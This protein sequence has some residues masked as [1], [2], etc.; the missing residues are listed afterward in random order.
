MASAR[1]GSADSGT[2]A[3]SMVVVP[4]D[5]VVAEALDPYGWSD[6]WA[7]LFGAAEVDGGRPGRVVQHDGVA[8]LTAMPDGVAHLGLRPATPA[9]AV[10]DWVVADREDRVAELLARAS[11]LQRRDPD[12]DIDQP[13][14]ANV[15]TMVIVCGLDRPVRTGRIQ[16]AVTQSWDAGATPLLVLT[17][18]DLD[19]SGDAA[20]KAIVAARE[21]DPTLD[22]LAVSAK[23]GRGLDGLTEHTLDRTI[24]FF[25]ESGAGKS[26]LVNALVGDDVAA[27]AAVR[28]GDAKGRHTT[29]ARTLHLLPAGGCL[30][31]TPGVRALGLTAD[32]DAVEVTFDDI[33]VLGPGCRFRDCR[34]DTEPGCAV[35]AAV[36]SG[37]LSEDRLAAFHRLRREAE[38]AV[39]RNDEVARRQAGKR[40]GRMVRESQRHKPG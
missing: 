39:L 27:T 3:A 21:A 16:R 26:T 30:I 38:S 6:R 36:E 18:T 19:E 34:H 8:V 11:L 20:E 31:D 33:S 28:P 13:V 24:V 40:F 9:L 10:G 1:T 22:V 17:K 29:T 23:A 5:S 37:E 35:R 7:A 2:D 14:A 4:L 12:D 15:D 32:P 25:G